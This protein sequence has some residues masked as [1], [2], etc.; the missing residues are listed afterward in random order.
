MICDTARWLL[1]GYY[2]GGL[3]RRKLVN[4]SISYIHLLCQN[5][6]ISNAKEAVEMQRKAFCHQKLNTKILTRTKNAE[7]N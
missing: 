4:P 1:C 3:R 2:D 7:I 5:S 6:C